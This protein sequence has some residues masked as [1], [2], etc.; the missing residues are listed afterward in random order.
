MRERPREDVFYSLPEAWDFCLDK[1]YD[2]PAYMRGLME[3]MSKLGVM[4]ESKILD[5][6]CGSGFPA[7]DLVAEGY[8]V[9]GT[10][11]SSEMVRQIGLN[12]RKKNLG[13]EAHHVMWS[14]LAQ[15]FGAEKFDFVYCRGNSLVY[16][17]SWEQNW[18]VPLRSQEEIQK[19]LGNFY[20]ILRSGGYVYIDVT[21]HTEKPHEEIIGTVQTSR[22]P[23]ELTWRIDHDRAH[24]VRTWTLRLLFKRT[25]AVK[26]Y[27]SYSYLLSRG[28]LV[29]FLKRAGFKSVESGV[30]VKG[31]KN[32]DVFIA[33]K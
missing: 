4:K 13:I 17:A 22:G 12:A 26:T 3:V 1:I 32:Y 18:I 20:Q 16:A 30:N 19:A 15:H 31:E 27:A 23:I 11:K 6:G 14:E 29:Q 24:K 7:I 25:A 5:A 10:D 21:K 9:T 8:K 2:K 28:E 33:R